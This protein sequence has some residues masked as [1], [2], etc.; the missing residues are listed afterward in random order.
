MLHEAERRQMASQLSMRM[1]SES[2]LRAEA[3]QEAQEERE[4]E[5]ALKMQALLRGQVPRHV[6]YVTH[7]IHVT[8]VTHT[9]HTRYIHVTHVTHTFH[10]RLSHPLHTRCIPAAYVACVTFV[11]G[12]ASHNG[13]A[14]G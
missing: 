8:H 7:V 9:L 4:R 13:R 10:T 11:T 5:S 1:K 6:T 12:G 3:A 2:D 14:R